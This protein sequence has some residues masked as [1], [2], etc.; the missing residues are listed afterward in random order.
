[1]QPFAAIE[2]DALT[3]QHDEGEPFSFFITGP[4][5]MPEN[6]LGSTYVAMCLETLE[7]FV[8]AGL[9][10]ELGGLMI[11]A[12]ENQSPDTIIKPLCLR[13]RRMEY[14]NELFMNL[15]ELIA[16]E[17]GYAFGRQDRLREI[18]EF[19]TNSAGDSVV[20]EQLS[21]YNG[22]GP[23]LPGETQADYD[24]EKATFE[25]LV[26]EGSLAAEVGRIF[27]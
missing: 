14:Y 12:L 27:A 6:P 20:P 26:Q 5:D 22:S 16:V 4:D 25:H 8:G 18:L 11:S 15:S 19:W 13:F 24:A 7:G 10:F 21:L 17:N 2:Q 23:C 3:L 1:M 9:A